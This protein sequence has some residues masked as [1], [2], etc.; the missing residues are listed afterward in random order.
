MEDFDKIIKFI[1]GQFNTDDFLPLHVPSFNSLEEEY[2]LDCLKST[3]VSSVGQ[4]VNDF[5]SKMQKI[6]GA[7]FAIATVN[8]TAALHIG[9]HVL[10][11]RRNDLV[12]TQPLT[13]VA[14][15]N[16]IAYTGADPVFIDVDKSN[17]GMCPVS[18]ETFLNSECKVSEGKCL[19]IKTGKVV[20][21]CVPMHTFGFPCYIEKIVEICE[22]WK[23]PV[24]E[25]AA[26]S[27]G[28][29]SNEK[30]T[31]SFGEL[32]I[33]SFNGNKIITAGGGGCVVTDDESLAKKLKYV[34]TT[35]KENHKWE[36]SHLEIG[37]NYRMPNLN[38][39][40][41]CAQ[42]QKL[43]FFLERKRKLAS[44]Y[45]QLF[46]NLDAEFI[47]ESENTKANYWLNTIKFKGLES[48][49]SFLDYSNSNGVMTRPV[50]NLMN[51][52]PM[53]QHCIKTDLKNSVYLA[54]RLV[55][56]TSSVI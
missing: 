12:L 1:R 56:I 24:L 18:L 27:L 30:H 38:A 32:G 8:G 25:D 36:Y 45:K 31:G 55:N 54:D 16:A 33:F 15:C 6:T 13:F 44:S 42:L 22:E 49:N 23:I 34:T 3:F 26:E 50:W 46:E 2:V 21:S 10:G 39:S 11:V 4:Y 20:K 7:K 48:R 5:E 52:L 40:L 35:A 9:L 29:F 17:M 28:S 37:F 14:T 53:F 19:H 47:W 43:D 41:V 51:T